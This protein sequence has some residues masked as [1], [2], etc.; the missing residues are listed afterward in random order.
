MAF[1]IDSGD[2]MKLYINLEL[3]PI[4]FLMPLPYFATFH[5]LIMFIHMGDNAK[6]IIKTLL[7]KHVDL[8]LLTPAFWVIVP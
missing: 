4:R 8:R 1:A 2:D 5:V 7:L 6:E 3:S